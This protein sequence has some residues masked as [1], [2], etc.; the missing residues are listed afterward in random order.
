MDNKSRT[1]A[2][3]CCEDCIHYERIAETVGLCKKRSPRVLVLNHDHMVTAWPEVAASTKKCG[4]F[5]RR[6]DDGGFW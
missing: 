6:V 1:Y 4:D 3:M 2:D 5:S